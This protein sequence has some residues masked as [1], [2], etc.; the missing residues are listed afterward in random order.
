M[1]NKKNFVGSG[2][3][4]RTK[5]TNYQLMNYRT[6]DQKIKLIFSVDKFELIFI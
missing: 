4:F 5:Q 6:R 3:S 2:F 1:I